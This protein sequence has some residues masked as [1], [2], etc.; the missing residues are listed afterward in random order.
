MEVMGR[1]KGRFAPLANPR[2][3]VLT[4]MLATAL[5]APAAAGC[6]VNPAT[7]RPALTGLTTAADEAR[8]GRE[9][10]PQILQAF[11][12]AYHGSALDAYVSRVGQSLARQT[13]RT[14][15]TWTF[16]I[17]NSPIVNAMATP[18][19]Y[20]YVTR[21]LLAL[22]DN[23]AELAGVLGHELGHITAQHHAQRQSR[24]TLASIGIAALAIATGAPAALIQGTQLAA[25]AYLRSYSREQ[26]YEADQLGARYMARAGYDPHAMVTFL[27]KLEAYT[28]LQET[29][30]GQA[31]RA[32][33]FG[34]LATHP[35]TADRIH[36]AI[37]A[38]NLTIAA[39]P[40]VA[41]DSYLEAVDG[42]LYG[43]PASQGYIRGRIFSH[44]VLRIRFEVPPE[45]QLFDTQ[46]AVFAPGPGDALI[47]FDAAPQA[48]RLQQVA[49]AQYV[50]GAARAGL[51]EVK[52][53][54]VTGLEAATGAL[55][56]QTN[57]GAMELRLAAIRTD[58]SHVYRFR[59]L[60]PLSLLA[61]LGPGNLRTL[62]SFRSLSAAEAAALKP[63]RLRVIT[64][65]QG[66]TVA[67]MANRMAFESYRAERLR[68]LNGLAPG[69]TL[70]PGQRVKIISE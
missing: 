10:H 25:L 7:G 4:A 33:R 61:Q 5:S 22:A 16:T 28:E 63:L 44:P 21:G 1:A 56:V 38:A 32:E 55:N 50:G 66:D 52:T 20:V 36:S 3:L 65:K 13:E 70:A 18:G 19:G 51:G 24:Q 67:A 45:Y 60:T 15:V 59:F 17:L 34:F 2:Q 48:E 31:G 29:M 69:A 9:Q 68:V 39:Q 62:Q 14:D 54:R 30:L 6:A 26:E 23:E 35:T 40:L 47:V 57:R 49:M 64:V 46:R 27:G 37:D 12:G 43:E 11:G 53:M 8:I 41:R 42:M 58:P